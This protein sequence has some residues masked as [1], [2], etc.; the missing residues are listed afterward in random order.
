M[1][2]CTSCNEAVSEDALVCHKCCEWFQ[3]PNQQP[4]SIWVKIAFG[5]ICYSILN[6]L[7]LYAL[8]EILK[9]ILPDIM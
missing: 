4:R 2:K 7:L 3:K 8:W 1:K 5:Y 9:A 6:I